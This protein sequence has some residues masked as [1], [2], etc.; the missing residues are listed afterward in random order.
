MKNILFSWQL[1]WEF[2]LVRELPLLGKCFSSATWGR[3]V[4]QGRNVNWGQGFRG[5]QTMWHETERAICLHLRGKE[6][7]K[8]SQGTERR[9][10]SYWNCW[11]TVFL[12][13]SVQLQTQEMLRM[14][15]FGVVKTS[16]STEFCIQVDKNQTENTCR[17]KKLNRRKPQENNPLEMYRNYGY[18]CGRGSSHIN[19]EPQGQ[20]DTADH[21]CNIT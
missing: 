14:G 6:W 8:E 13:Y 4:L 18:Y 9:W 5:K 16:G 2:C 10:R 12:R 11:E 3:W 7:K 20:G 19:L 21:L 15:G 17:H 1:V